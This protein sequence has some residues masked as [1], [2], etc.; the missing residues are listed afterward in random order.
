MTF[1]FFIPKIS[2]FRPFFSNASIAAFLLD[3]AEGVVITPASIR[4]TI[5]DL[6]Y[7]IYAN[8]GSF[9]SLLLTWV[10]VVYI[11]LSMYIVYP[12]SPVVI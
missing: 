6:I 2:A 12:I 3:I 1:Y 7:L 11:V 10:D 9:K 8:R 4:S 5:G